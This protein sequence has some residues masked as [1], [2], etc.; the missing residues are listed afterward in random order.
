M[1]SMFLFRQWMTTIKMGR[2]AQWVKA[3]KLELGGS[4]FKPHQLL[5]LAQGL[6]L[7]TRLLVTF[8]LNQQKTV[9]NIGLVRVFP[10]EGPKLAMGQPNSSKKISLIIF[11]SVFLDVSKACDKVQL[12]QR[13]NFLNNCKVSCKKKNA[14]IWDQKCFIWVFLA[15]TLKN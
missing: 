6:N 11:Q 4:Q 9:I 1:V 10:Q 8:R 15:K 3:L 13:T 12:A 2:V 14:Y 5:S 7:E